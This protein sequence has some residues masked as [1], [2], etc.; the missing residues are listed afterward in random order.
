M[1]RIER[2]NYLSMKNIRIRKNVVKYD[3]HYYFTENISS[4]STDKFRQKLN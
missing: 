4:K 3:A 2:R 1:V